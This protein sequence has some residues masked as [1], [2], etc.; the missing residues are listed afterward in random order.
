[1]ICWGGLRGQMQWMLGVTGGDA[2]SGGWSIGVGMGDWGSGQ[3]VMVTGAGV[4]NGG[5]VF[6]RIGATG[7]SNYFIK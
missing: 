5:A 1:M 7:G 6:G 4:C 3:G 2:D